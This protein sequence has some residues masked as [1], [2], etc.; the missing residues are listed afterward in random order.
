MRKSNKFIKALAITFSLGLLSFG[1]WK[2]AFTKN[3]L[4]VDIL[5]SGLE[6]AHYAPLK[7]DDEFSKKVFDLYL[8]R[9]DY[10]KKFLL[11]ADVDKLSQYKTKI[12]DEIRERDF[13]LFNLSNELITQRIQQKESL[14]KELLAKP[15][16]YTVKEDYETDP[17]KTVY[18]IT[19][20]QLKNEWRKSLQ[21][22]VLIRL[23]DD[24]NNQEKAI[25]KKDTSVKILSFDTLEARARKKVMKVNDDWFKRLKKY[26][27]KERFS[28]YLNCI[29]ALYDPHTEFFPPKEKK[30]FDQSMSGQ[31]EG[32]GAKLQ[33][34]DGVVKVSEIVVGSPSYKQGDLKAGDAIIKVAQGNKEPVEISDMDLDDAIELIKGKK[35][36]EVRLTVKKPDG[37]MKVIPIVRDVIQLEETFAQSAILKNGK[38]KVGYIRLPV[39]YSDFTRNGARRC[40]QDIKTEAVKLRNAGVD[41]IIID[42]RDNGGGSLSEV[43]DMVGHFIT[44]GPVVQVRKKGGKTDV[45]PDQNPEMVYDGPMAVLVNRNS[46]SASEIFAAAMQD[47]KRAV[48]VGSP[49]TFGKGTVQQFLDLD[50][51]LLPEFDTIKPLGAVK[52]TMQKFYRIN[53][54]ATQLRGV[55]P[56][57]VLPDAYSQIETGEKELDFPMPWDEISP[58][59]YKTFN[60]IDY[61]KIRKKSEERVKKNKSF[62]LVDEEA[63]YF[64]SRKD[65]SKYSLNLEQFRADEKKNKDEYKK[66]EDLKTEIKGFEA[67]L[68]KV[69]IERMENDTSRLSK[70]KKWAENLQKDFYIY[71]TSNMLN[72]LK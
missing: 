15:F 16:D 37:T 18:S 35:G 11:Q 55:I 25:E 48:I 20:E 22:Q 64:K 33:Q 6:N 9:L 19:D 40:G 7:V 39:F 30:Q 52:V 1:T 63:G 14:Y 27:E 60:Y 5:M 59:D 58:A 57:V 8:K 49:S 12:D 17:D 38:Q 53:G 3:Q 41:G 70:E 26:S 43:I 24:L 56:D 67:S 46:A 23:N 32:I 44:T 2:L 47:Y 68:L 4:I 34:K 69:D 29:T 65:D 62:A 51:Y 13:A 61:E 66:F 72:D 54:G 10:N 21:Y 31:L 28:A 42:L 71:E 50:N 45:Y 36:T